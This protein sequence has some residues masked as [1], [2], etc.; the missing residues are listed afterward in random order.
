MKHYDNAALVERIEIQFL[1][2]WL[3]VVEMETQF[4]DLERFAV[5]KVLKF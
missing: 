5:Q 2:K 1:L 3:I 4:Q